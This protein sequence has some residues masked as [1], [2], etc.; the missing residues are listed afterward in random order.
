MPASVTNISDDVASQV[1]WSTECEVVM[2]PGQ[3]FFDPGRVKFLLLGSGLVSHLWFGFGKFGIFGSKNLMG[4]GQKVPGS[5]PGR[6]LIYARMGSGQL[7]LFWGH[8]INH[9]KV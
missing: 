2:G 1:I 9:N 7:S 3:K 8:L 5:N 6:P 4:F